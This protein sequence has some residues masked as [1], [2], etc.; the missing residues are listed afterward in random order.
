MSPRL[1]NPLQKKLRKALDRS[2]T[3][4]STVVGVTL[5]VAMAVAAC[6]STPTGLIP[7]ELVRGNPLLDVTFFVERH[8]PARNQYVQWRDAR[9]ADAEQMLKIADQP[10]GQWIG[11]WHADVESTVRERVRTAA[12][13]GAVPLLVL[14]NIPQRDCGSYSAGGAGDGAA[15]LEWTREVARGIGDARAVI[16]LEPDAV[17]QSE[18]LPAAAQE[19][20]MALLREAVGILKARPGVSLY[21]DG[22]NPR[23]Q[24]AQRMADLLTWAGVE[25]ADGFALNVSN[26]IS[27]DE[28]RLYGDAVSTLLGGIHFVIDTSRNGLGPTADSEWCNPLGRAL[29][30]TPRAETGYERVDAFLWVKRPGES[31]GTCNGGPSAGQ[32]WADYA[33]GL[34]TR[35]NAQTLALSG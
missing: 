13:E 18:C 17:A 4:P 26:T 19:Q 5:V 2:M 15:Y 21:V 8:S 7:E 6:G 10:Q 31:D 11:D 16:V 12:S 24:T 23:W 25:R 22:G 3:V 30:P 1:R 14:Y 27:V 20:R 35:S 33:L 28:N 32:W 29:G 9:P 34:A